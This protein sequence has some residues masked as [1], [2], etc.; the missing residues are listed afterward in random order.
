MNGSV[1]PQI[2]KPKHDR[3][4]KSTQYW[5]DVFYQGEP[6]S[7]FELDIQ[8]MYLSAKLEKHFKY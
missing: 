7:E 3:I 2:E 6:L 5:L 4:H 1:V 8:R